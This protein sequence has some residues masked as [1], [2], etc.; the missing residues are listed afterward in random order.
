M[1]TYLV[2]LMTEKRHFI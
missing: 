1:T 2:S